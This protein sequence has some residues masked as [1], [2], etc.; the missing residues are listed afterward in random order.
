MLDLLWKILV[1]PMQ[2]YQGLCVLAA[3]P[4]YWLSITTILWYI[5]LLP[6][7]YLNGKKVSYI[8]KIIQSIIV[9]IF[10]YLN[11]SRYLNGII[12]HYWERY[13]YI[14]NFVIVPLSIVILNIISIFGI[15][16]KRKEKNKKAIS[17][18]IAVIG[19]LLL[20]KSLRLPTNIVNR[21]Q[22]FNSSQLF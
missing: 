12:F 8:W 7:R 10:I 5:F 16:D 2:C 17:F 13:L 6:V 18:F 9:L 19:I 11:T 14:I 3:Y 1:L 15:C 4:V 20:I 21:I 22:S